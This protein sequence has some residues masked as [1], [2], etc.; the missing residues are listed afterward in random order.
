SYDIIFRAARIDAA[1]QVTT[2]ARITVLQNGQVIHNNVELSGVTGAAIDDK[3]GEPGPLIL[4][5]HGND[6]R[7]RNIW[8][9]PLP[10][11]GSDTYEPR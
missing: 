6:L 11:Q 4:Q 8:Y 5:D 1:G 7:F 10:L 9:V 3:V 2:N